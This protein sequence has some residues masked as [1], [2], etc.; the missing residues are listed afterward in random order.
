VVSPHWTICVGVVCRHRAL[1]I[2]RV[3]V[4]NRA[5]CPNGW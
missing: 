3:H 4:C 5:V 2:V 1:Y